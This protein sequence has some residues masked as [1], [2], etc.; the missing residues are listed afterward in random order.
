MW[1]GLL[2][3]YSQSSMAALL[4][5]TVGLAAATGDRRVRRAV[6]C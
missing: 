6:G 5:I 1:A 3:S 4:V 2:F